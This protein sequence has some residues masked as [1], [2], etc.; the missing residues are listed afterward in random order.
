MV[1]SRESGKVS[2]NYTAATL[3]F[4]VFTEFLL[5]TLLENQY[6]VFSQASENK[7]V[8]QRLLEFAA[9]KYPEIEIFFRIVGVF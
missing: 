5:N 7:T 9:E 4:Q 2:R 3:G 6:P 1:A 8:G